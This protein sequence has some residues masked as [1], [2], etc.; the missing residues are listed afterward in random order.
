MVS[1]VACNPVGADNMYSMVSAVPSYTPDNSTCNVNS[2]I[3]STSLMFCI[4]CHH[5]DL[6]HLT[7]VLHMVSAVTPDPSESNAACG[8]NS[9]I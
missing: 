5:L 3:C 6:I 8:V 4:W 9:D 1:T 7:K 2:D